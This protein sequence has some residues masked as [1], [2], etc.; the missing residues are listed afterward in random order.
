MHRLTFCAALLVAVGFG[1]AMAQQG[2]SDSKAPEQLSRYSYTEAFDPFFYKSGGN[3]FR[4]ASG[5]PGPQ[6]WQNRADYQIAVTLDDA[7]KQ[8]SGYE[9]IT[10]T[11][12]SPDNL[13]FLWMQLDQNLFKADSKGTAIAFQNSRN[14]GHGQVFDAGYKISSVKMI[15]GGEEVPLTYYIHDT[16]MQIIL[17]AALRAK[18]GKMKFRVDYSFIS[19]DY[20][21]DRM[22]VL[23][24]KKGRIFN[25]AQWYPRMFVYDDLNGWN[26]LPYAG[27]SEFYLEYGDFDVAITVPASHIVVCS[28]DLQNR[29]EV[30]TEEQQRRWKDAAAS[31]KTVFIRT[32]AEVEQESS[33]PAG[34]K[35]LTWKFR[36]SNARDVAWASSASF[37]LDAARIN[38]PSGKK[39]LAVSAYPQ[40]SAGTT[41]WSRATEYTKA[42]IEHYSAKWMEYPYP[43][44]TNV[45]GMVSGMEYPGIVFCSWKDKNAALFGVTD[46]EF[47]HTWFPMIV[48]SNERLHAWMDE[49][50]DTFINFLSSDSFNNGEYRE[51]KRDMHRWAGILTD[52]KFE[53]VMRSPDNMKEMS[54]GFLAYYKPGIGLALLRDHILGP[55]RF[56]RAFKA[57]I[58]RWAYKHPSPDDFFRTIENVSGENLAW[59][60][61]GWFQHNWRTDLGVSRVTYVRNNPKYGALITIDNLEQM[62]MPVDIEVKTESGKTQRIN[63]PVE[64]WQRNVSWTLPVRTTERI[65]SVTIDPDH[66]IPDYNSDNNTWSDQ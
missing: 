60:W 30:Y 5:M 15:S 7:K 26:V 62:P 8:I 35:E 45:A 27:P 18:G 64:V 53:S 44:A 23:E 48:G 42:S 6:Y 19:P 59:F 32:A 11:N 31:D 41:A 52:P 57:Y 46:H 25:V 63:L 66:V 39:A 36:I 54:I 56:D 2:A 49:G 14:G 17:P 34:K 65:V 20:G 38:L 37:V 50:F 1:R 61:R 10:Y 47:G 4:S 28:G 40:E 12:N 13:D 24:T 16:R 22:G 51:A 9:V 55:E 21:S 29:A 58:D 43:V 33:R 3:L